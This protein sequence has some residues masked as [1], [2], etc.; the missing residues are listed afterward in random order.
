MDLNRSGLNSLEWSFSKPQPSPVFYGVFL[1]V[2]AF[3]TKM[4]CDPSAFPVGG[5]GLGSALPPA[6]PCSTG[7]AHTAAP[8][9]LPGASP[10]Y[11]HSGN[12]VPGAC[13]ALTWPD[14]WHLRAIPPAP[15]PSPVAAFRAHQQKVLFR[16]PAAPSAAV[17]QKYQDNRAT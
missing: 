12:S 5:L 9:S 10:Q 6:A 14:R 7:K 2:E 11:L 8:T 17:N 13:P 15:G 1:G 3:I 4:C 16:L